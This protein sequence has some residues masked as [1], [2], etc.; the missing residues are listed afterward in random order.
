[1]DFLK[2]YYLGLVELWYRIVDLINGTWLPTLCRVPLL[3]PLAEVV[4]D[5]DIGMA[6]C[7]QSPAYSRSREDAQ[8]FAIVDDHAIVPSNTQLAHSNSEIFC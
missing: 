6:E 4:Q 8:L 3:Y 7:L 5:M 1:M 2:C